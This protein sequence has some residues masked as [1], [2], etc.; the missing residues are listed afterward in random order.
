MAP[1]F[2]VV[3]VDRQR[4]FAARRGLARVS[5]LTARREPPTHR[6]WSS[7]GASI[8]VA[9]FVS[10]LAEPASWQYATVDGVVIPEGLRYAGYAVRG[11]RATRAPDGDVQLPATG[12]LRRVVE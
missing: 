1:G 5:P 6:C 2:A 4:L 9:A 10:P 7:R 8:A 11:I 3:T 12:G